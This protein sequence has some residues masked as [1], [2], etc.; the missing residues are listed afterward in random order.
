MITM[1]MMIILIVILNITMIPNHNLNH[2]VNDL[3]H[4]FEKLLYRMHL[5]LNHIQLCGFNS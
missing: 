2:D 3:N 5:T 4:D 1:M